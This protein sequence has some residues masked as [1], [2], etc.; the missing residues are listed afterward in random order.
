MI[1]YKG[2]AKFDLL[3][4]I[5]P[6][7]KRVLIVGHEDLESNAIS[8]ANYIQD[9]Y[10]IKVYFAVDHKFH[11]NIYKVLNSNVKLVSLKSRRFIL[12]YISSKYVFATHHLP[13]DGNASKRQV[14]VNVWHGA[15]YKKLRMARGGAGIY[16]DITLATSKLEKKA[17]SEFFGVRME[18]I[19][20]SGY[21]RNDMMLKAQKEKIELK[22]KCRLGLEN[23]NKIVIWMPTFRRSNKIGEGFDVSKINAFNIADFDIHKFNEELKQRN[24]VCLLKLHYFYSK[25][26]TFEKYS[27]IKLINDEALLEDGLLLYQL[28]ACTDI[29]ITD[30]SSVQIDYTLLDQ[31]IIAFS[32]DVADY[33]KTQGL[34]FEDI[35]NWLPTKLIEDDT[36]FF[37]HLNFLLEN[38]EDPYVEKRRKIRD[39]FFK[40]NDDRGS[41][42]L[43]AHVLK[44]NVPKI[45]S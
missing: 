5:T 44:E 3:N 4:K 21:P 27:N 36:S 42:R 45:K 1:N 40:Y 23:Y 25:D 12:S 18:S 9:N 6:K 19:F 2:Y 13:F 29:L 33:K 35:E 20:I 26:N 14:F 41:E 22:R 10:R 43:V 32:K 37:N 8:L 38:N 16:A 15:S 30:F 34:Y 28:L 17:F 39:V 11:K 24:A 7:L 31:P